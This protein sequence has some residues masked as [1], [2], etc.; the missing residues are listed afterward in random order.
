MPYKDK[1]DWIG[2]VLVIG[3]IVG[4]AVAIMKVT[5]ASISDVV[6]QVGAIFH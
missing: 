4:I 2:Y 1:G 6:N 5:N 3:L